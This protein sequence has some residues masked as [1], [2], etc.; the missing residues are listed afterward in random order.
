[1]LQERDNYFSELKKKVE[2]LYEAQGGRPVILLSH[3]MGSKMVY[4]FLRWVLWQELEIMVRAKVAFVPALDD[5]NLSSNRNDAPSSA[6]A[7]GGKPCPPSRKRSQASSRGGP[8]RS[9]SANNARGKSGA[10]SRHIFPFLQRAHIG[11]AQILAKK[12]GIKIPSFIIDIIKHQEDRWFSKNLTKRQEN[13]EKLVEDGFRHNLDTLV[14]ALMPK[15]LELHGG[16]PSRWA[17]KYVKQFVSLGGP[18]LGSARG[19]RLSCAGTAMGLERFFNAAETSQLTHTCAAAAFL[20]PVPRALYAVN[21]VAAVQSH[22]GSSVDP[23][24]DYAKD[25]VWLRKT[26]I[27]WY[28]HNDVVVGGATA[29]RDFVMEEVYRLVSTCR[30]V[31]NGEEIVAAHAEEAAAA[32]ASRSSSAM[33]G[34]LPS[35]A[36]TVRAGHGPQQQLLSL[37]Q[38]ATKVTEKFG[39]AAYLNRQTK[40]RT[41]FDEYLKQA[42]NKPSSLPVFLVRNESVIRVT[43]SNVW[44]NKAFQYIVKPRL[45]PQTRENM[46]WYMVLTL[47]YAAKGGSRHKAKSKPTRIQTV[48][49]FTRSKFMKRVQEILRADAL[50]PDDKAPA[51]NRLKG[52]L[53]KT[54]PLGV[55]KRFEEHLKQVLHGVSK[56]DKPFEALTANQG[57]AATARL[58]LNASESTFGG[59]NLA[60]EV[61]SDVHDF[62]EAHHNWKYRYEISR[63]GKAS[64][65]KVKETAHTFENLRK[66]QLQLAVFAFADEKEAQHFCDVDGAIGSGVKMAAVNVEVGPLLQVQEQHAGAHEDNEVFNIFNG[67]CSVP[68]HAGFPLKKV[69]LLDRC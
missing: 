45:S 6:P 24:Y 69:G 61:R 29:A 14:S 28:K 63:N 40:I 5:D 19:V 41:I 47:R 52:E 50:S 9:G 56:S 64:G 33:S 13:G 55:Y 57:R 53:L 48:D 68:H 31:Q 46:D 42:Q 65:A 15:I 35:S 62:L 25:E 11:R 36:K 1:V 26:M 54:F 27:P 7:R 43:V 22:P 49:E 12:L 60:M 20:Y 18:F 8:N 67:W 16:M 58:P 3:S 34:L 59:V 66:A 44:L 37:S 2:E 21:A 39:F 30:L 51:M 38:L 23:N 32:A 10:A 4:Y 17:R